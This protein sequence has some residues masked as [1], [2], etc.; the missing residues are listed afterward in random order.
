MRAA[1]KLAEA[2]QQSWRLRDGNNQLPKLILGVKFA[3][4]IEVVAKPASR[5]R[6]TDQVVTKIRR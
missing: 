6:L 5:R 1:F 3:D 2:A 4:G